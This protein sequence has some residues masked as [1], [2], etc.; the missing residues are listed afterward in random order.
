MNASNDNTR[1]YGKGL[2]TVPSFHAEIRTLFKAKI[3]NSK[4]IK[5]ILLNK[6]FKKPKLIDKNIYII[7][8][9]NDTDGNLVYGDATPCS[10]CLKILKAIGIKNVIHSTDDGKIQKIKINKII[11]IETKG[12]TLLK[13]ISKKTDLIHKI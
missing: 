3:L 6:Q 1:T 7:R 4:I 10:F 9:K 13:T 11:P 12:I 8:I 2:R 5:Q